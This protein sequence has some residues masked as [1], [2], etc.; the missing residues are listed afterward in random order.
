M[1]LRCSSIVPQLYI[2]RLFSFWYLHRQLMGTTS[3]TQNYESFNHRQQTSLKVLKNVL[4]KNF[5]C[6]Q[7]DLKS[8]RHYCSWKQSELEFSVELNWR[9]S[10][11]E[12]NKTWRITFLCHPCGVVNFRRKTYTIAKCHSDKLEVW[13]MNHPWRSVIYII[14]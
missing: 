2:R 8:A 5:F 1:E 4:Y 3:M 10:Y 13:I 14:N 6:L 11:I 9:I 7:L 12:K